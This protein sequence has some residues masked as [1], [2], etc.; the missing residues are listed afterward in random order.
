MNHV[1]LFIFLNTKM[2]YLKTQLDTLAQRVPKDL[3]TIKVHT[4]RTKCLKGKLKRKKSKKNKLKASAT[5]IDN[6][7]RK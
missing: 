6:Q 3:D 7:N 4:H 1:C 5:T 2:I